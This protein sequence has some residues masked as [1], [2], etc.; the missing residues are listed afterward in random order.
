M[1]LKIE[2]C[3][4]KKHANDIDRQLAL[5]NLLRSHGL[6]NNIVIAERQVL[7]DI[8]DSNTYGALD[9]RYANEILSMRREHSPLSK[10]LS[11]LV[12]VDF[13]DLTTQYINEDGRV[14]IKVGYNHFVTPENSGATNLLTEN[15]LDFQFYEILAKYYSLFATPHK[16]PI[17]FR[18]HLGAGSHS[19]SE[20]ERFT[21]EGKFV[22]CIVDSDKK[23]PKGCEGSTSSAFTKADRMH[24]N[25][26]LAHV[27][28]VREAECLINT[29]T[30][31]QVLID[32]S[33]S[34][35]DAIDELKELGKI[36]PEFRL[37]FDY[38]EGLSLKKAIELDNTYGEFWLPR[39]SSS[40]RFSTKDCFQDKRCYNCDEC[41]IVLGFGDN[42]LKNV[43]QKL[44]SYNL[45]KLSKQIDEYL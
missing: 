8:I 2:N 35:I 28:S 16:L 19:K 23:H 26:Q 42:L 31:E 20:F 32:N 14:V 43:V 12:K 38:K 17:K 15:T 39:L 18:E 29:L 11:F 25:M 7:I 37:F 5:S 36:S 3:L 30:L 21:R 45:H 44:Q 41:P 34:K 6:G 4:P 40:I 27:L 33:S 1:L 13:D 9:K 10:K 24:N 22:L